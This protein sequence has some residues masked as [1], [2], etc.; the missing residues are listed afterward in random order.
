M[1]SRELQA[2][3][4][5]IGSKGGKVAAASLSSQERSE[6]ARKAVEARMKKYGQ[7]RRKQKDNK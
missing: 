1:V 6:R 2:Y 4:K 7:Q 3:F 5:K